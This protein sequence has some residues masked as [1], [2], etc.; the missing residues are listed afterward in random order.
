VATTVWYRVSSANY[1]DVVHAAKVLITGRCV[2]VTSGTKTDFVYD[3]TPHAY[4]N[5]S[6]TAGSFVAGE[7]IATSNW[8]TV[9]AESEGL[10]DNTFDYVPLVGTRIENYALTIVFGKI[11]AV[12]NPVVTTTKVSF[13]AM[14][15][16]VSGRSVVTQELQSTY[17]ELPVPTRDDH[18]FGGWFAS[19]SGTGIQA[20]SQ[21][22]FVK[23]GDHVLYA[24][25]TVDATTCDVSIFKWEAIGANCARILGFVNP[26]QQ[27]ER[28]VIPDMIDGKYVTEIAPRAFAS[29]QCGAIELVLPV[30]CTNIGEKAF[31]TIKTTANAPSLKKVVFAS[32]RKWNDPTQPAAVTI[33]AYAFSSETPLEELTLPAEI[34]SIGNYAFMNCRHLGSITILGRPDVGSMPFRSCG[35]DVGGVTVHLDPALA[36][37]AD[38]MARLKQ[39][40]PNVTVRTDAV[41]TGVSMSSVAMKPGKV[42]LTLSV[43]RAAAWGAVDA[44]AIRVEHLR[45]LDGTAET[46]T[47]SARENA[48]GTVTLEV[49]APVGETGFLRTILVK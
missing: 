3:G 35:M 39:N 2:T 12:G 31:T 8:A 42:V 28:L 10:V 47:P 20:Q 19:P 46:L 6:V 48:D 21:G 14:G 1:A 45:T 11:A 7:G 18:L 15:G 38:Y 9:V 22:A 30:F 24:K 32:A 49:S 34:A 37:D 5:L 44:S 23:H 27:T 4:T 40:L 33:G 13:E 17:G 29:S 16:T 43:D 26:A 25:W 36:A 41:V